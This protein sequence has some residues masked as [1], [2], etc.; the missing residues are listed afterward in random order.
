M[1]A[2]GSGD[3]GGIGKCV[4]FPKV[5]QPRKR[6]FLAA[7]SRC[8]SISQ[9]AKRAKVDRRSH[10]NWLKDPEYVEAYRQAVVEAG[11]ALEDKLME[12]AHEGNV[13]SAIFLLKGLRPEKYRERY[14][15]EV[16]ID[17][18]GDW[19]SLSESQLDKVVEVLLKRAYGNNPEVMARAKQALLE[20]G[21]LPQVIEATAEP[22]SD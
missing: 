2:N 1:N 13:T 19:N 14:Q 18:N 10:Y 4:D 15:S 12:L 16:S 5:S 21:E 17:W 8:G 20:G 22:V 6:A 9:A 7:L 3:K 11:D